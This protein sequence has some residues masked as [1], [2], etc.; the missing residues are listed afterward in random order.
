MNEFT[1]NNNYE[2]FNKE[3]KSIEIPKFFD[4]KNECS[5]KNFDDADK[6]L[7]CS[8]KNESSVDMAEMVRIEE[9]EPKKGGSYKEVRIANEGG[10]VHHIPS[11]YASDMN[12][13]EGPAILMD[14][15]EHRKTAS[16]GNSR[17]AKEYR[18]KQKELIEQG[19]FTESQKMDIDDIR[20]KFG[21][22]YDEAITQM[23]NYTNE[24][25]NKTKKS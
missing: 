13:Y 12:Y 24:Q 2:N 18:E 3:S 5:I 7:F 14:E 1:K 22:K 20:S 23:E 4:G 17:E 25:L 6:P 15:S 21:N 10:E 9:T 16:C 11:D 8:E 19:F